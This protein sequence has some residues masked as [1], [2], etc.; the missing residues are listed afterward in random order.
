[1]D[2]YYDYQ[3]QQRSSVAEIKVVVIKTA[4]HKN[5]T[6][7]LL[8]SINEA[9]GKHRT[10]ISKHSPFVFLLAVTLSYRCCHDVTHHTHNVGELFH[11]M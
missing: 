7:S 1:M 10:A 8:D 6:C 2:R 5:I 3:T 9:E 4:E 11:L